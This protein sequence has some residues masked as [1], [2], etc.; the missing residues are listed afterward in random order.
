MQTAAQ[1][2]PHTH[3]H[4]ERFHFSYVTFGRK[5]DT[6][7]TNAHASARQVHDNL[8]LRALSLFV[9][10]KRGWTLGTR[11]STRIEN[12][13]FSIP[14]TCIYNCVSLYH[15]TLIVARLRFHLPLHVRMRRTCEQHF[16]TLA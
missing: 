7:E 6:S 11:L 1:G 3:A 14:R 5:L 13:P 10:G 2:I 16:K 9:E 8:V 4:L 12:V 15:V